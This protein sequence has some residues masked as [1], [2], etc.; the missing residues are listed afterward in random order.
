MI[1][2]SKLI[3]GRHFLNLKQAL[4]K[5]LQQLEQDQVTIIKEAKLVKLIE[6]DNKIVGVIYA[7]PSGGLCFFN[8]S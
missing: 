2:L 6:K 7:T 4:I 1:Y 3:S 8:F 5:Y